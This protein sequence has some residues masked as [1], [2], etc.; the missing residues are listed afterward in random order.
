MLHAGTRKCEGGELRRCKV[1]VE[2]VPRPEKNL[3]WPSGRDEN[4]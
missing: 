1:E 2:K 3:T 4:N